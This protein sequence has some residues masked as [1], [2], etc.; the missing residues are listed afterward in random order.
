MA[1]LAKVW[2]YRYVALIVIVAIVAVAIGN[3]GWVR[4]RLGREFAAISAA[5]SASLD[6]ADRGEE[7]ANRLV[8]EEHRATLRDLSEAQALK[9][10]RLLADPAARAQ[11]L[12]R[13]SG[14]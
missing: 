1:V 8:D 2:R 13:I 14:G 4:R 5:E 12:T 3:W 6:A 7:L 9:A 10:D 11:W